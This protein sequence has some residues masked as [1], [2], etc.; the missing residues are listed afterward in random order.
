MFF[1]R[2]VLVVLI[3]FAGYAKAQESSRS[4]KSYLKKPAIIE[5]DKLD[6]DKDG[7]TVKASGNVSVSQG[8]RTLYAD[9]IIY[10]QKNDKIEA[11]G[12][13]SLVSEGE[14]TLFADYA[15]LNNGLNTGKIE[16]FSKCR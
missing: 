15:F 5:A 16:K 10:N 13:I 8:A 6:Y 11:K 7:S 14:A 1:F 9:E 3:V 2:I 12:N 4:D